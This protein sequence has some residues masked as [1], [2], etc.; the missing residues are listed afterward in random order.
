MKIETAIKNNLNEIEILELSTR[1]VDDYIIPIEECSKIKNVSRQTINRLIREGVL[2][3]V[4]GITLESL[5]KYKV[6]AKKRM[7]GKIKSIY[8]MEIKIKKL[9]NENFELKLEKEKD[10]ENEA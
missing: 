3:K 8:D 9:E 10:K 5:Q 4:D 7:A 6:D 2:V 1:K